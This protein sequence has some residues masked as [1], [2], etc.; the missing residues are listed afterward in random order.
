MPYSISN[1]FASRVF[2]EHPLALWPMDDEIYYISLLSKPKKNIFNWH[3]EN[4]EEVT[5]V[6]KILSEPLPTEE[7][8][9]VRPESSSINFM[10]FIGVGIE[11]PSDLDPKKPT[12][13]VATFVYPFSTLIE[14][15]EIGFRYKLGE[16]SEYTY[17]LK[18][19]TSREKEW[20]KIAHTINIPNAENVKPYVKVNYFDGAI[21]N[22]YAVQFNG[23]A[24]GQWSEAYNTVS[25]GIEP[26][27]LDNNELKSLLPIASP[28]GYKVIKADSYGI[29][30]NKDGY[31]IVDNNKMLASNSLLPMVFGSN[32]TTNVLPPITNNMPSIVFPGQGFLNQSGVFKDLTAEF[33][34]RVYT[35][36]RNPIKIFGQLGYSDGLYVEEE[37]LTLRVGPYS[38]SY[39]V[40][41][42]YRPMLIHIRYTKNIVSLLINGELVLSINIEKNISFPSSRNNWLGFFGNED[43]YPFEVDSFAIYPYTVSE[44]LAKKRYVYGQGVD[45]AENI[46]TNIG[47]ESIYVDFPFA[48]YTSTLNYPDMTGWNAGFFNNLDVNS[49]FISF[50]KYSLPEIN[51]VGENLDLFLP[52]RV[53]RT[54]GEVEEADVLFWTKRTWEGVEVKTSSNPLDDMFFIQ[55]GLYPFLKLKPNEFYENVFGSIY[56]DSANPINSPVKSIFGVFR[57]PEQLPE[58]EE[59]LARFSNKING[60]SL[61]ISI[62]ESGI[63]YKYN[64]EVLMTKEVDSDTDFVAGIN[65]EKLNKNYSAVISNFFSNLQNISISVGGYLNNTFSG[66][67]YSFSFNGKLFSD[68]DLS[69]YID[70]NGF[71]GDLENFKPELEDEFLLNYIANYTYRPSLT[72]ESLIVDIGCVGYWEDSVPLSYFGKFVKDA[73]SNDYYDLDMIQFNVDVPS[74]LITS[75]NTIQGVGEDI[76]I[77][78]FI[79]IQDSATVGNKPYSDYS[80]TQ[81]IGASRVLDF[82]N[83]TFNDIISNKFEIV[84]GTILFPPKENVNFEDYYITS[85]IEMKT[86]GILNTTIQLR[87]MSFS[88]LA[89]DEREFYSINSRGGNQLFPF[90]RFDE[91]Y[92]YKLKNPFMIYKDSTPYMHLTGDS[93]I[94]VLPKGFDGTRGISI[95]INSQKT[96]EYILGGIQFWLFYNKDFLINSNTPIGRIRTS[97]KKLDIY[98]E[99]EKDGNRG[100]IKMLD[101]N[102]GIEYSDVVYY[103]NGEIVLNPVINP[104]QWNSI[105]ISFKEDILLNDQIGQFEF[106]EGFLFNNIALYQKSSTVF[107]KQIATTPWFQ[108]ASE[109]IDVPG[110]LDEV[111]AIPWSNW[112]DRPWEELFSREEI[113][114]FD[115]D[116]E[117]IYRSFFGL[118][119]VVGSDNTELSVNSDSFK[120]LTNATW[121][122]F[123]GRTV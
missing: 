112:I 123:E 51:Y 55:E 13:S 10:E 24:V 5:D 18:G 94:S 106:Y 26:E 57:S 14:S 11:I 58:E 40:H 80:G 56:F 117:T 45:A 103:E 95:P 113:L 33:W 60:N 102:L 38:K 16:D 121:S 17:E 100:F 91:S 25:S 62:D 52:S 22:D 44:Q 65:V 49:K 64:N 36:S 107:G 97:T 68:K 96:S 77:S 87:R 70:E 46:I 21:T 3:L 85:H 59:I 93:G 2:A 111:V 116:G 41:K 20:Q 54:W 105:V 32:N 119:K 30:E 43:V 42:W 34:L 27:V 115:I 72:D 61:V 50:P 122:K 12:I 118:S 110:P 47:G 7:S 104:Q 120:V 76:N 39:F 6:E 82:D 109:T 63:K 78:T 74:P 4:V 84:D 101:A 99:P 48:K 83:Y 29:L 75:G 79:T 31:Y 35:N 108:V 98:L 90:N 81:K 86:T 8:V 53:L 89:F 67:I 37:F 114:T 69:N 28:S 92:I 15:F 88:S 73:N 66:R 19:F 1:L 71:F 9:L 23:T